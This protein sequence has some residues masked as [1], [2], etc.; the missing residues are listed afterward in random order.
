MYK[1]INFAV[2]LLVALIAFSCEKKSDSVIDPS[3]DS[4]VILSVTKS[5]DT[6]STTS[7]IPAVISFDLTAVVS[8][9]GGSAIASVNCI[10]VDPLTNSIG[11]FSLDY[12]QDL[13]NGKKYSKTISAGNISCLLV[14]NYTVQVVAKNEAGLFSAQVNSPLYVKD[15]ANVPPFMS[16]IAS[17]DSVVRPV[18]GSFDITIYASASDPNGSCDIQGVYFNAYRPSGS[19]IGVIPMTWY[20]GDSWRFTN[21]VLPASADSSYGYF[22]YQFFA[23]DRSNAVSVGVWDSI[24]FVRP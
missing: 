14:G 22:K 7:T 3:Y 16:G 1:S 15:T 20:P 4:P 6:V 18:S 17:P 5:V 11:T 2:V 23:K 10:L 13:G 9:N 12:V 19:F 21:P 24:K 8:E